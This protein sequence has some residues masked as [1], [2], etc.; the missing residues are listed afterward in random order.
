M[1]P[2]KE[3]CCLS[4]ECPIFNES[5]LVM[6]RAQLVEASNVPLMYMDTPSCEQTNA[7]CVLDAIRMKNV[8]KLHLYHLYSGT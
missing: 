1:S 6:F 4:G 5:L 2:E 7:R 3:A 8:L